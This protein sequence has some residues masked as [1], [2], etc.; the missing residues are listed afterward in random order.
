[1]TVPT[2]TASVAAISFG[3]IPTPYRNATTT[4]RSS[5]PVIRPLVDPLGRIFARKAALR[6]EHVKRTVGDDPMQPRRKRAPFIKAVKRREH[7]LERVGSDIVRQ[8]PPTPDRERRPPRAPPIAVKQQR[9]T[10]MV[11]PPHPTHQIPD[12]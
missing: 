5:T 7:A 3:V 9:R 4:R 10:V 6:A 12:R 2:G 1:L 8:S 11:T